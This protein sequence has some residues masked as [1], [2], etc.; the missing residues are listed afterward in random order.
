MVFLEPTNDELYSMDLRKSRS[1]QY[2]SLDSHGDRKLEL[3]QE[4]KQLDG[5]GQVEW[6]TTNVRSVGKKQ[7]ELGIQVGILNA[8]V[9]ATGGANAAAARPI[10]PIHFFDR[11]N[12]AEWVK[13]HIKTSIYTTKEYKLVAPSESAN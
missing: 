7:C 1:I 6:N 10:Q 8:T 9:P 12:H 2:L 11:D 5:H 13:V 3:L 4:I